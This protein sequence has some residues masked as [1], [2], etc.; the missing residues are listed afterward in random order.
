MAKTI[1][2]NTTPGHKMQVRSWLVELVMMRANPGRLFPYYWRDQRYKWIYTNEIKA[3]SKFIKTYG[4]PLVVSVTIDNREITSFSG[5]ADVEYLLQKAAARQ[6]RLSAPKD[7]S[8]H[9]LPTGPV[10]ADVRDVTV[11]NKRHGLFDRLKQL[12]G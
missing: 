3:V 9:I 12:E 4:E 7:T 1:K 6:E 5:Y 11:S 10:L 2:S 8:E